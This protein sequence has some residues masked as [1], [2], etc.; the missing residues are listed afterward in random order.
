VA[1][2]VAPAGAEPD[3]RPRREP[4]LRGVDRS[5]GDP[6]LVEEPVQIGDRPEPLGAASAGQHGAGL[7]A[8]GDGHDPVGVFRHPGQQRLR[9]RFAE[10]D[11]HYGRGVDDDHPSSPDAA[12]HSS[13]VTGRASWVARN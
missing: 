3:A 11:R 8:A 13:R 4:S 12:S 10:Q 5:Q 2:A 6:G 1:H 7:Q 9:R